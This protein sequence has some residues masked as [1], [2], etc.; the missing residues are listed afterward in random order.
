MKHFNSLQQLQEFDNLESLLNQ[1]LTFDN[2][3][4]KE[5]VSLEES[6]NGLVLVQLTGGSD[7]LL[8]RN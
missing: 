7:L 8:R 6:K 5:F 2:G 1:V 3:N 4:K